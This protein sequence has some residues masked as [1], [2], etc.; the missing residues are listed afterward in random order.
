MALVHD[1]RLRARL[2]SAARSRAGDFGLDRWYEW[3]A[4]LW[5]DLASKQPALR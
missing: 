3:L 2:G 5:T 1:E 4:R